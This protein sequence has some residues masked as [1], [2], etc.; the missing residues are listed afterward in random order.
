M[1]IG[2]EILVLVIN[3]Y[4]EWYC[5]PQ[6]PYLIRCDWKR[7]CKETYRPLAQKKKPIKDKIYLEV[8]LEKRNLNR[9]ETTVIFPVTAN[10][11]LQSI[12]DPT[13]QK[14]MSSQKQLR[15]QI[16]NVP[17]S[18]K[19]DLTKL[20]PGV[21]EAAMIWILLWDDLNKKEDFRNLEDYA[22]WF[23][24]YMNDVKK[25]IKGR[26]VCK[27]IFTLILICTVTVL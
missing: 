19:D 9:N 6:V 20:T 15:T 17:K 18:A 4:W 24:K 14:G 25:W 26:G 3:G 1:K 16:N 8:Q 10:N 21:V 2:V 27:L 12:S 7:N 11:T 22:T 23:D 5:I 13:S